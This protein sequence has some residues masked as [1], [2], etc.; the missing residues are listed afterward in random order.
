MLDSG[1][2]YP[3]HYANGLLVTLLALSGTLFA[4]DQGAPAAAQPRPARAIEHIAGD[5]YRY[6]DNAHFSVFLVT[7]DGIIVTDPINRD[8]ASWLK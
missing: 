5:L 6:Q 7:S 4:A 3:H 8:V 1:M 2:L